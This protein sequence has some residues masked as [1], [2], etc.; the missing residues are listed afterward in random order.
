MISGYGDYLSLSLGFAA[1]APDAAL[2]VVSRISLC[3]GAWLNSSVTVS[4]FLV[5]KG[6][7]SG[8]LY[9]GLILRPSTFCGIYTVSYTHLTLPTNREV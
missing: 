8:L 1:P 6:L 5:C 3:C 9:V 2:S 7:V 4:K